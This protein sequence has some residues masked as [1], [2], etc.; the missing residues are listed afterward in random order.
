[1]TTATQPISDQIKNL[2]NLTM[3][4]LW[5]LWDEHFDRRPGHHQRTY[6]ESR[7]TY[8]LQEIA[9]GGLP[10]HVRTKLEKIGETGTVPNQKRRAENEL[11][12]GTTLLREF[13]GI[14]HR[15]TVM[16]DGKFL[17]NNTVFKSLSKVAHAITGTVYSGP[18]FFGLK[19]TCRER[20]A[21]QG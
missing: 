13:N 9:Y 10:Q 4:Q 15:V 19:P 21:V 3:Y 7:L 14:T 18:V 1:M 8:K 17:F 5:D 11:A 16:D 20:K 6:L 2:P 12:P